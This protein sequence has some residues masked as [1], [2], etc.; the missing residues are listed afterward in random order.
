MHLQQSVF[1]EFQM[2]ISIL[3]SQDDQMAEDASGILPEYHPEL[4]AMSKRPTDNS[5]Q[6]LAFRRTNPGIQKEIKN[7]SMQI[8]DVNKVLSSTT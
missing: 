8:E 3:Q 2:G 5:V 1:L 4:E 6:I 7:L